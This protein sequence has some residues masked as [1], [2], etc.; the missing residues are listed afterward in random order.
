M[1]RSANLGG[2]STGLPF[3]DRDRL[4]ATV[5]FSAA[6]DA[7]A[8]ALR[9][10][11]D[12]DAAPDRWMLEVG[13]GQLLIMP[14][15]YG[16]FATV[17]LATV[18]GM[19]RIQGIAVI[20]DAET[21][22]PA[23]LIDGVA[24]TDLRTAAV[25]LL[26]ARLMVRGPVDHLAILGRGPQGIAHLEALREEFEIGETTVLNSRSQPAEVATAIA[27]ADLVCCATTARE[28]LF[29]GSLVKDS[30]L[31]IGVGSHEPEA[32]EVD[33]SLVRRSAL[34]VES[35]RAALREAGDLVLA[36]VEAERL[37]TLAGMVRGEVL[38]DSGPRLFKSMG[39]SWEDSV[40]ASLALEA[41]QPALPR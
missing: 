24:L 33:A 26:A 20:F 38:P 9:D 25:S 18:G 39:M 36:E 4:R 27:A 31:V 22:A 5:S 13:R 28:P 21:L 12:P 29:A 17:K 30:A 6:A 8:A 14:A 11:L 7:L 41:E 1:S 15:E 16:Q 35:R 32:R 2:V 37:T 3:I 40:V 34:V 10:G 23:A 19:P